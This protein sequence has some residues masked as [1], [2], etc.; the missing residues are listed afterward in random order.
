M[1]N[2]AEKG[3]I[4]KKLSQHD[5]AGTQ[6]LYSSLLSNEKNTRC[7]N[8]DGSL[9]VFHALEPFDCIVRVC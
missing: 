1:W 6:T 2:S 5:A 4:L 3:Q 9:M 8:P 7:Q